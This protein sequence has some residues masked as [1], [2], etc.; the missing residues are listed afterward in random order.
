MALIPC[1]KCGREISDKAKKCPHCHTALAKGKTAEVVTLRFNVR[2]IAIVLLCVI[3]LAVGGGA[4]YLN[5]PEQRCIAMTREMIAKEVSTGSGVKL[6]S[7][8]N[9][10]DFTFDVYQVEYG[11][12]NQNY[13][14]EGTNGEWIV[15]LSFSKKTLEPGVLSFDRSKE[16]SFCH[17]SKNN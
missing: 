12:N 9:A 1:P 15:Y 16:L 11:E 10:K 6:P 7:S 13:E 4:L 5:S 14:V 8:V 3:L 2:I 17:S